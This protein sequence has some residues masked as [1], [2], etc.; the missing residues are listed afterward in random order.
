MKVRRRRTFIK[1]DFI[2]SE[3]IALETPKSVLQLELLIV[4]KLNNIR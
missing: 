1:T 3:P 4:V 2:F